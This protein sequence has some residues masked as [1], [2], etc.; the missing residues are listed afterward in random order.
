MKQFPLDKTFIIATWLEVS[1]YLFDSFILN[2]WGFCDVV[3]S[4]LWLALIAQSS[5]CDLYWTHALAQDSS[6]V[7]SVPPSTWTLPFVELMMD[8]VK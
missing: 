4:S 6:S 5:A 1:A 2:D 8:T 3:G 7:Y